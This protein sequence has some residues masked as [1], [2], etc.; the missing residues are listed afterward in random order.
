MEGLLCFRGII[1]AAGFTDEQTTLKYSYTDMHEDQS[2]YDNY[3][4]ILSILL[5]AS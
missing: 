2:Y 4:F 5:S 3:Y 1:N